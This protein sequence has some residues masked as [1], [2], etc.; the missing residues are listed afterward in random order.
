[1]DEQL[2]AGAVAGP[3][4]LGTLLV[5]VTT[6]RRRHNTYYFIFFT[7]PSRSPKSHLTWKQVPSQL[8]IYGNFFFMP[9]I[10][11]VL[12]ALQWGGST[13]PWSDWRIILL[14]T[15]FAALLY[16]F[17]CIQ[18]RN[19]D[20]ATV[21]PKLLARRSIWASAWFSFNLGSFSL[22][23]TYFLPIWFQA[24]KGASPIKSGIMNLPMIL[25]MVL[26]SVLSGVGVS[27]IGYCE[28]PLIGLTEC[29]LGADV[30]MMILA[31]VF[32]AVG[33]TLPA[34]SF[35]HIIILGLLFLEKPMLISHF[36]S[37]Q[38]D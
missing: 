22:I 18:F 26:M 5:T 36:P 37:T 32:M 19:P 17:I 12:L 35:S 15:I 34:Q 33:G 6:C 28:H 29:W 2:L 38:V 8:D 4:P 16:V 27:V 31:S 9:A 30:P 10:I 20:T 13:Y 7:S 1:M 14:F 23:Y 24:V 3:Y 25:A 11:S 21:S